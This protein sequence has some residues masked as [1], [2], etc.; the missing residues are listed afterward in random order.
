VRPRSLYLYVGSVITAGVGVFV[1]LSVTG[2]LVED[3]ID[4]FVLLVFLVATV[5]EMLR[6][7]KPSESRIS[8]SA[9]T[10]FVYAVLLVAGVGP[11]VL[12][13]LAGSLLGDLRERRAPLKGAFNAA[14]FT[15]TVAA[16]GAMLYA[17]GGP[18]DD[19][20]ID[21]MGDLPRLLLPAAVYVVLNSVLTGIAAALD[22]RRPVLRLLAGDART[23]WSLEALMIAFGPVIVAARN[24]GPALLPLLALPIIINV[25][26]V[27]ATARAEHRALYD[28]L[29][30]APNRMLF[31]DRLESVLGK[32]TGVSVL[33]IDLARFREV[34][35]SLGPDHG[36]AIL[37]EV[38]G[39]IAEAV[40]PDVLVARLGADRF[41][42]W[43]VSDPRAT[44]A[45]VL[46]ALRRAMPVDGTTVNLE[47]AIGVARHPVDGTHPTTLLWR[48][49]V[50]LQLA[51]DDHQTY[52]E[53][54]AS[55]D[56]F[57]PERVALAAELRRGL[58]QGE[59]EVHF[60]PKISLPDRVPCGVEALA[61]WRH[62]ERGL[63]PPGAFIGLAEEMGMIEELT[64]TVLRLSLEQCAR[65]RQ[66]GF[67]I[68]VSVNLS[69]R[70]LRDPAVPDRVAE[71]LECSGLSASSLILELTETSVMSNPERALPILEQLALGGVRLSVD[72]FGTGYSSLQYLKRLP[73]AELKID[74]GFVMAMATDAHDAAIVAMTVDLG[75]MLELSVVAEGVEDEATLIRL[76][77]LGCDLAQGFHIARPMPADDAT[78]WLQRLLGRETAAAA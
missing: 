37:R 6:I 66:A 38:P 18:F 12:A 47:A 2:H 46:D 1:G 58:C 75:H 42:T 26:S 72:D 70:L 52:A 23:W 65:W 39:R 16:A 78:A 69:A 51:K 67:D 53:Y 29:T 21:D 43:T 33:V 61:R 74:R 7:D 64:W 35:N 32:G 76:A 45:A 28:D 10:P 44:A 25:R 30:Q 54:S 48:A 41:A 68:P 71:L 73:I 36:D 13:Q 8:F 19:A 40:E 55:A 24:E 9:S 15:L 57:K 20:G 17:L 3:R 63:V 22:Q 77:E 56:P 49:E 34:T 62:P 50:A 11:A 27:A 31:R 60:Q 5:A 59:I 4:G 14:Q